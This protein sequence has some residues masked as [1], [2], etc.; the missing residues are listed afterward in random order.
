MH[1]VSKL[2]PALAMGI[3]LGAREHAAMRTEPPAKAKAPPAAAK[4]ETARQ[5]VTAPIERRI[6]AAQAEMQK[7]LLTSK[8]FSTAN[9]HFMNAKDQLEAAQRTISAA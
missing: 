9:G 2:V 5:Q 1:G 6:D 3:L 7:G 8:S 4:A